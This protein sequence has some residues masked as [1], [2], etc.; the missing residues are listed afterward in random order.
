MCTQ[1]EPQEVVIGTEYYPA[2]GP[3]AGSGHR[4][5]DSEEVKPHLSKSQMDK[6]LT[7][8]RSHHF[9]STM[10]IKPLRTSTNLLIGSATHQGIAAHYI[11]RKN[12]EVVNMTQAVDEIWAPEIADQTPVITKELM[13]AR[14]DSYN[15]INLFLKEVIVDPVNVETR[16]EIPIINPDN[17]DTLPCTLVGIVDLVDV[18]DTPS[19]NGMLHPIEIKTRA[20]KAPHYL[21]TLSLEL[22]C[23]AYWIWQNDQRIDC[24]VPVGYIHIIKTKTPYIQRQEGFREMDDFIELY[25]TA[26]NVYQSI[27]EGRIHKSE[28]MHCSW[29]DYLPI[30]SRDNAGT[31]A[32]FGNEAFEKLWEAEFI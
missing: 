3:S 8:P 28:G 29:C 14:N 24:K 25:H 18:V 15:Y 32:A 27:E 16:F 12:N 19:A 23:Y 2:L 1:I 7:C 5:E 10:K 9:S 21:P 4:V 20:S 13:T 31:K 26:E 22:T 6:Y 17:G 11:A 30:C